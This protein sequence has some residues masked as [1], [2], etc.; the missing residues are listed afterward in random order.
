MK[1]EM[2]YIKLLRYLA[3]MPR[4]IIGLHHKENLAEFVLHELCHHNCFNLDKAAYLIDNADFDCLKGIAGFDTS[5]SFNK[6]KAWHNPDEFSKH[7]EKASFNT[8]VRD[9]ERKSGKFKLAPNQP[10]IDTIAGELIIT[11]PHF[12]TFPL[13]HDN[14]G[15]FVYEKG[16]NT[17]MMEENDILNGLGLL[18]LCPVF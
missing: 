6:S 13:K 9:F 2:E 10:L 17:D 15:I 14:T 4:N 16:G 5:E 12:Y 8:R 3:E 7:M 1:P 11:N 18:G